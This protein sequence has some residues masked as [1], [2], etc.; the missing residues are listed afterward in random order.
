MLLGPKWSQVCE[1][2][3]VQNKF[4]LSDFGCLNITLPYCY[5]WNK[6]AWQDKCV[7][8]L[9]HDG[10]CT[11]VSY[12]IG[13]EAI[14]FAL[15]NIFIC[16]APGPS[17]TILDQLQCWSGRTIQSVC[18]TYVAWCNITLPDGTGVAE[19]GAPGGVSA[20]ARTKSVGVMMGAR[21]VGIE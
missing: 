13:M 14:E 5:A 2:D 1:P 10:M 18:L 21:T 15:P 7:L 16:V 20:G 8:Q 11:F 6:L 12:S 17:D 9:V 4:V 3:K 19:A